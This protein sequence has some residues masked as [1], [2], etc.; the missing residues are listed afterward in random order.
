MKTTD[1][2]TVRRIERYVQMFAR[3][4][5]EIALQRQANLDQ[6]T[7]KDGQPLDAINI[8]TEADV[9]IG[10]FAEEFFAA[11]FPGCL[12]L[13]EERLDRVDVQAAPE[14]ALIFVLDPIDGTLFYA[15][16]AFPWAV[17]VGCFQGGAALAGAVFAPQLGQLYY[18]EGSASFRNGQR[19]CARSPGESLKGS[20]M[21]RHVRAYQDIDDFP[22]YTLSFGSPALHLC[23]VA[24][25]FA[26]GCV[27]SRH[28]VHDV[29]GSVKIL[30]NAGA[31]M[32][33][34]SGDLPD[35]RELIVHYDE[36]APECYFACPTGAFDRLVQYVKPRLPMPY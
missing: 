35:W 28:R 25:G 20:I 2:D 17:S 13:Q 16:G 10:T 36:R 22:G 34:L 24:S 26:C 29:A 9:E 32:R 3:Q 33:F 7:S 14:D 8:L 31:E 19:I 23:L 1:P 4:A 27:T 12:V 5:G 6:V 11:T 30:Q 18:S 21:I 15:S